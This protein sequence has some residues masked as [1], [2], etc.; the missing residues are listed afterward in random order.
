MNAARRGPTGGFLQFN[1]AD[2]IALYKAY[3]PFVKNGGLFI[4]TSHRYELGNEVFVMIK[5]PQDAE[6]D[7][8][9]AV[10]RVVWISRTGGVQKPAGIGIQLTDLPENAIV[11]EKIERAIAGI[12]SE[13]P[14]FTM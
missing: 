10:G 8:M 5:L 14:T 1:P 2:R 9:S 13:T 11:R 7:R 6:S 12:S 3:M 4:N